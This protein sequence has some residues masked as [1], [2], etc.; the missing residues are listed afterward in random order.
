MHIFHHKILCGE[1]VLLFQPIVNIASCQVAGVEAL[2]RWDHPAF[3]RLGAKALLAAADAAG[4]AVQ[5]GNHIRSKAML[6]VMAWPPA[7]ATLYLSLN[8]TPSDLCHPGFL[9]NLTTA[10]ADSGFP[11]HRLILEITEHEAITDMG[12]MLIVLDRLGGIGVLVFIDDFGTGFSSL[13]LLAQ[14]SISGFKLDRSFIKMKQGNERAKHFLQAVVTLGRTLDL[15]IT[16]EGVEDSADIEA[17]FMIGCDSVQ[18][19]A[20][21]PPVSS[22]DLSAFVAA[23]TG[24]PP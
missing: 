2:V 8:V 16:A 12:T 4:M 11:S 5:L 20:I 7:L 10:M 21:L 3:G 15:K 19:F 6:D 22:T 9:E 23:W 18:G 14:A 13:Y 1:V 17:A 24:Q